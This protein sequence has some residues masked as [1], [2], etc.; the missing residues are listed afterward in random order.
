MAATLASTL[1]LPVLACDSA[2]PLPPAPRL[3]PP[4]A[5]AGEVLPGV[6]ATAVP[7]LPVA[8]LTRLLRSGALGPD[9]GALV[10]A[11]GT[12]QALLE[13]SAAAA[14][15]PA[16]LLKLATAAAALTTLEPTARL[17]TRVVRGAGGEVVLVGAGDTTLTAAP[18]DPAVRPV[19]S[20]LPA[21]ADATAEALRSDGVGSVA[22]GFDDGLFAGPSVAPG[23]PATYVTSGVVAPVSALSVDGGRLR[24]RDDERAPDP[25]LAAGRAFASLLVDRGVTVTGEVTR[26]AAPASA[27]EVAAVESPTV[28]ELTELMLSSSDNDLAESL[29][30]LVAVERGRPGTFVDGT[31]AVAEALAGL[32]VP[33]EGLDLRDGSGLSRESRIVPATLAGLLALA[34]RTDSDPALDHLVSGLPVAGF[35]GTLALRF[36]TAGDRAA[37]G[38]ARAKTGTLTGV[39]TL[40]GVTTVGDAAVV[41]VVMA[42]R[43]PGNTLAARAILDRF[44]A[45]LS[46]PDG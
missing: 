29:L 20:G 37:A 1:V 45:V 33:V 44:V 17:R 27:R 10:V 9:P 15:I 34:A 16:S 41:F 8:R 3:D 40:A 5:A 13:Q 7:P 2:A 4:P 28:A 19:R 24:P 18:P 21:L 25:A 39:S 12:G 36:A 22:V 32:G 26:A 6:D 38:L 43:V 11:A 42:D 31:A 46:T 23:W 30:R 35:S 14:R